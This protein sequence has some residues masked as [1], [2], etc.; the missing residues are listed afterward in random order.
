MRLAAS[1]HAVGVLLKRLLQAT[2]QQQHETQEDHPP[3]N[4]VDATTISHVALPP[5]W[6]VYNGLT[7]QGI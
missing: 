5:L 1:L 6:S 3:T 4:A 2:G 7:H